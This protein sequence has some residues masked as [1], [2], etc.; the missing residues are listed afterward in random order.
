MIIEEKSLSHWINNFY[1]YGSWGAR[2][3]I[4]SYEEGGGEIPEE[5]AEKLA[6][7]YREHP[8]ADRGVLCDIRDLYK[9][10]AVQLDGPKNSL[11][12]NRYEYRFGPNAVQN[13]VWKN[14]SSPLRTATTTRSFPICLFI[15]KNPLHP[16]WR[17]RRRLSVSTHYQ[18][19]IAI[20]GI[21]AGSTSR[22]YPS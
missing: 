17:R 5:V 9:H 8:P 19:H 20:R 1:G 18:A 3:W 15:R 4:I 7:F 11:F 22:V 14:I 6:Y 10:V 21:I 16:S 13:S 12:T 2:S